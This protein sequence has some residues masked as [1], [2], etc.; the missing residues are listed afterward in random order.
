MLIWYFADIIIFV[1]SIIAIIIM[2]IV[3][4][5][6]D[7]ARA[8]LQIMIFV[9]YVPVIVAY[10]M[11]RDRNYGNGFNYSRWIARKKRNKK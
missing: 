10:C 11:L 9:W 4:F 8:F 1:G 5:A 6:E 7:K 2:D 3:D